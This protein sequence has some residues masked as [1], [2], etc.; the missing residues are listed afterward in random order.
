LRQNNQSDVPATCKENGDFSGF[1]GDSESCF[2]KKANSA[3]VSLSTKTAIAV[4]YLIHTTTPFTTLS[5]TTC[6]NNWL[7]RRFS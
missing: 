6:K 2:Y 1:S 3:E 4:A 7:S 5:I